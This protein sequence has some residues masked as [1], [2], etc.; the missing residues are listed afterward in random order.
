V[1]RG[2][3]LFGGRAASPA[4]TVAGWTHIKALLTIN[5]RRA[6]GLIARCPASVIRSRA[7]S[8]FPFGKSVLPFFLASAGA[9]RCVAVAALDRLTALAA[10]TALATYAFVHDAPPL[11]GGSVTL[12]FD[13]MTRARWHNSADAEAL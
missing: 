11:P 8:P 13:F 2:P 3:A 1:D 12:E 7:T 10:C 4:S 6:A 5:A 9:I